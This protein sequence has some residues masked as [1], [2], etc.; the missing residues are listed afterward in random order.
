MARTKKTQKYFYAVGRRKTASA[1]VK[2]YAGTSKS[3]VNGD[4]ID[5]Y[6]PALV[7][8]TSFE[9]PFK[10]TD[11]LG[12]YYA[13]I[14]VSGSGK[15]SQLEAIVLAISRALEKVDKKYRKVLKAANLLTVDSRVKERSK[16]GQAGRARAKKQSPKR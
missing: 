3:L 8:K 1:A 9:I 13:H 6:F 4:P 14:K 7:D 16:P 2:L 15:K 12:K 11:N 10:L 5:D